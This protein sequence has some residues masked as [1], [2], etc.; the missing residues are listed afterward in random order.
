MSMDAL[1]V[2]SVPVDGA[3]NK[4]LKGPTRLKVGVTGSYKLHFVDGSSECILNSP[5]PAVLQ[6]DGLSVMLVGPDGKTLAS[7]EVKGLRT[8]ELFPFD[9]DR[10]AIYSSIATAHLTAAQPLINSHFGHGPNAA[11]FFYLFRMEADSRQR[12]R[13]AVTEQFTA[14]QIGKITADAAAKWP[15]SVLLI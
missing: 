14:R 13:A 3:E 10:I 1:T 8:A 15:P 9:G 4:R 2:T 7:I 5:L 12:L 6:V 11:S